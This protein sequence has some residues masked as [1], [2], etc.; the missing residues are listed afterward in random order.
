MSTLR[1]TNLQ[2]TDASD[3]NIVL[4]N[5]RT[6]ALA[7]GTASAPALS[8]QDDLDTGLYSP[9]ANSIA[10]AVGGS[11]IL[12]IASTGN[13]TLAGAI[14]TTSL[15]AQSTTTNSWFQTGTVLGGANYVWAAKDT[16]A[17]VWHSGLQTD[18]DLYIGGDLTTGNRIGLTGSTGAAFFATQNLDIEST[19]RLTIKRTTHSPAYGEEA[20]RI[21]D[22]NASNVERVSMYADGKAVFGNTSGSYVQLA[23][24]S[25]ITINDGAIDLYQA[26][27]TATAKPFKV[28]SDVGGTKVE[29][30][31]ITAKGDLTIG[32][33]DSSP[34]LKGM[35]LFPDNNGRPTIVLNGDGSDNTAIGIYNGNASSYTVTLKHD[36]SG[37]FGGKLLVNTTSARTKYFNT[38]A[39][40]AL[41]NFEGTGNSNRVV[42]H[43]HND[44]SGGPM[45]V[46]GATGGSTAGSNALV[47]NGTTY[48]FLSFQGSDGDYLIE[49]ARISAETDGTPAADDMPGAIVF[50]TTSDGNDSVDRRMV[51]TG[52]GYLRLHTNSPGIQFNNDTAA[53]NALDDY[54][55]GTWTPVMAKAGAAGSVTS[56]DSALGYYRKVG[57]LLWLSFYFYKASGSFGSGTNRWYVDGIP[58]NLAVNANSA[59]QFIT[60]GYQTLNG[61]QYNNLAGSTAAGARWQSNS[62]NGPDTLSLYSAIST[63]NWVSGSM[64]FSGCGVVMVG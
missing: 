7:D 56:P 24:N 19:G 38:T 57:S 20:F 61:V 5:D 41:V 35:R 9:G 37:E 36:G 32:P 12:T 23:Q 6:A 58:Y 49:A 51:I 4:A 52:D 28:Q 26:T 48:G 34:Y 17:N 8:F 60:G 63:T 42:S 15:S 10:L 46:L 22:R 27:S 21:L 39:Y 50:S 13:T 40:G 29:K 33:Y 45:L 59:Y 25:G 16:S 30:V 62:V 18:G 1:L 2:H 11:A 55:E 44:S 54:E 31:S 3:P 47:A 14:T 43:V 64:E 53:A